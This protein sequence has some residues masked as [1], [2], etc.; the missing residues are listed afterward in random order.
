MSWGAGQAGMASVLKLN[1]RPNPPESVARYK[2]R[3]LASLLPVLDSIQAGEAL[4]RS[5]SLV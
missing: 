2:I 5:S 1:D 3:E 4:H